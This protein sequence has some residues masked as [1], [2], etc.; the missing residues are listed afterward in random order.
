MADQEEPEQTIEDEYVVAKYKAAGDIANRVLKSVITKCI[1]GASV[2]DICEYGDKMILDECVNVFKKEKEMKKGVAFPTSISVNNCVCH[3]SP[4]RS[5][6]D[7][8]LKDEDVVKID[9]GV[10]LDGFI[11]VVA[12]TAVVG[13]SKEKKV[14]GR[15]AD[16]ILAAHYA[17]DAALK[18]LKPGTETYAITNIVQ[19]VCESYECKPIEGML[20]HQLKQFTI[21]GEKTII[22]NPNEAQ[23]KEHEKFEFAMHEVY[24]MDVLVSTGKG[25]GRELDTKVTI[26]KKTDENYQVKLKA[27]KIFIAEV[28]KKHGNMPFNLRVFGEEKKARMAVVE[29]V[30]HQ[31]IDPFQVLYEKP[32]EIVA[33][34]KTTVLILPTGLVKVTGILFDHGMYQSEFKISDPD[35]KSLAI[36]NA[37]VGKKKRKKQSESEDIPVLEPIATPVAGTA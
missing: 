27:S 20:S 36:G 5:E 15:K 19:K 17:S 6:T 13:A 32:G 8:T 28:R 31:L 7:Y 29:C 25:V 23:R 24:A 2:C 3:F 21:D 16:V 22:Q 37:K 11:A 4:L 18:S 1:D 33:Q 34:F 14:K 10:H 26:F 30:N 12:H 9:L 35:L